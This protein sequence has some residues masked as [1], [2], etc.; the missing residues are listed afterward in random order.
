MRAKALRSHQSRR[1]RRRRGFYSILSKM[2]HVEMVYAVRALRHDRLV[3][4]STFTDRP[5]RSSRRSRRFPGSRA[6]SPATRS[7]SKTR[8][9]LRAPD[10]AAL[11]LSLATLAVFAAGLS[12][13]HYMPDDTFITLRYRGTCCAE[14]ASCSIPASRVEGYTKLPLAPHHRRRGKLGSP[15]CGRADAEPRLLPGHAR[16]RRVRGAAQ[17]SSRR[18]SAGCG[19]HR[20]A[21]PSAML[22][23]PLPFLLSTAA[24]R[25]RSSLF[26]CGGIHA[27][28]L[29]GA[30][31]GR[32]VVFAL[33]ASFAPRE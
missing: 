12:A 1:G 18:A 20:R 16:P 10:Y 17:P 8:G 33:L 28:A 6:R 15:S 21:S 2:Q 30:P 3:D 9:R 27:P 24:R 25:F 31:G 19:T 4:G 23:R 22:A 7:F 11:I 32:L 5:V 13:F 26:C 29:G 14:K